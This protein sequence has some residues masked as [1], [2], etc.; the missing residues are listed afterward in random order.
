MNLEADVC[1]VGAGPGGALLAYLLAANNLSTIVL[2]RHKGID[3]EFRGEHLNQE[4]EAV[5]RAYGLYEQV[6]REGLLLMERVEYWHHGQAF[7]AVIPADGERH[8]G[9]HIPQRNLL[10]VLLRAADVFPHYKLMMGTKVTGVVTNESGMVTGVKAKKGNEEVSIKSTIVVGAD[11]RFSTIRKLAG[12][13]VS[14]IK[15]GY[16]LLWAKIP[17]P[18]EWKPTIRQALVNGKQFALFTQ[19]GGY[20]QIGWNIEE[21]SYPVLKKQSFEPFIRQVAEAFPELS[22]SVHHHIRSWGD[23]V[24]L[25]V[26]SSKCETWVKDGLVLMGDAAHTM[27]PTGAFGINAS[28]ADAQVLSEVI[29]EALNQRDVSVSQLKEFEQLRRKE[30]EALQEQQLI[31][32]AAFKDHFAVLTR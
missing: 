24:L 6:E 4:G 22:E 26:H 25:N 23:F 11:G 15:H 9:I 10:S 32:E 28:L 13:P 8:V 17:T 20:V 21:G 14:I 5:L 7:K 16:D 19:A 18:A 31:K 3:K 1:I 12:I 2:E 27:S 29:I 30:V